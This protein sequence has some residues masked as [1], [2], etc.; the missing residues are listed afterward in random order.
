MLILLRVTPNASK[1]EIG[2]LW[3]GADGEE[4]LLVRVAAPPD[5]GKANAAVAK[6]VAKAL[7]APKS[8]VSIAAGEKD[9]LK[10]VA[11]SGDSGEI[12]S[13]IEALIAKDKENGA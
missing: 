13:R 1:D 8:A 2:G 5:K 6:L 3:C 4:R 11:I 12:I 9:R 10:T 7:G